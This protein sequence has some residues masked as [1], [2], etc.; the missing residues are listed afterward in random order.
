MIGGGERQERHP[1]TLGNF[2]RDRHQETGS[3]IISRREN[4][5]TT[6]SRDGSQR[7]TDAPVRGPPLPPPSPPSDP[8][9]PPASRHSPSGTIALLPPTPPPPPTTTRGIHPELIA[10]LL[11]PAP[12]CQVNPNSGS[13]VI[14]PG[15]RELRE[16]SDYLGNY[17][18]SPVV[19]SDG[20][21]GSQPPTL[22]PNGVTGAPRYETKPDATFLQRSTDH[23][24]QLP[25]PDAPDTCSMP[26]NQPSILDSEASA[27]DVPDILS[28]G[29]PGP[30]P[31]SEPEVSSASSK[32]LTILPHTSSLLEK[33]RNLWGHLCLTIQCHGRG[34]GTSSAETV[35]ARVTCLQIMEGMELTAAHGQTLVH[36]S[37]LASTL[38]P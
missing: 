33:I 38:S 23:G 37:S 2:F 21:P 19:T 8:H 3:L 18:S 24:I 36:D 11:T 15:S 32:P 29:E 22:R 14:I 4:N 1:L 12:K 26:D 27:S 17:K 30:D 9:L 20:C 10:S 5:T 28:I 34:S 25:L 35:A 31:V 6:S 7:P 13:L 16:V